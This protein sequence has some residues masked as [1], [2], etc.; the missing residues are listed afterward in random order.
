MARLA[1]T[2]RAAM[3]VSA[4]DLT[5]WLRHSGA[6][7]AGRVR[8]VD[9][10]LEVPTGVSTLVFLRVAYAGAPDD[11][12]THVVVKQPM[13]SAPMPNV[14][15]AEVEFYRRLAPSLGAPP[16]VRCLAAMEGV[17]QCPPTL[18]LED[19]RA[20]HD[21][22][23]WPLPPSRWQSGAAID[24][25]ADVH[26]RWWQHPELGR[27][28]GQAH[29][30]ESLTTMVAGFTAMLPGF[31]DALGDAMPADGRRIYD[32]VFDSSLRP[33]LRLTD[34]R[35]LC[36]THGDAHSWNFLFPRS[37]GG[38]AV[39]FDW[40]LWHVDVGAR[41]LAFLIA[42]HWSPDRRRELERP[43]LRRY[44]ARLEAAGVQG[45]SF[46]DLLLDYRRGAVRNLTFPLQ[47]WK[48]AM[49]PEA[50]YH[51]LECALAAYRDLDC[52]E[53]LDAG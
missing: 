12:P 19:L 10:E 27:S 2:T 6:L 46:D 25:L 9:T 37:G 39:L 4:K 40:Q 18:V 47:L 3:T 24:A 43:V 30:V 7:G 11:L 8:R 38:P 16:L 45:Y 49:A 23:P 14:G 34:P 15:G 32:R 5:G 41:D 17:G 22:R 48:R 21:H 52:D 42:Q 29:T 33:W 36:V 44:H 51:R 53:I 13:A 28:I 20:T 1:A 50:W 26:A 35:A 31:L